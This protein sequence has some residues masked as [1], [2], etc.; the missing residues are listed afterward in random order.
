MDNFLIR[1]AVKED[2]KEISNIEALCFPKA[3]AASF[4]DF[5]ERF[6]TFPESFFVAEVGNDIVGFINGCVTDEPS[7]P[8]ELYHNADLHKINGAYQTVFGLAV[9][10]DFQ[11]QGIA[12]KLMEHLINTS[13]E[14]GKNGIILTCKEKL[15]NFYESFG[16]VNKGVSDSTHGNAVWNNMFLKL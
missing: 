2:I 3:E 13:R 5:S 4:I 12:G 9:H 1:T 8:D 15:I 6:N 16:Y 10:P 14:R 7:L 11:H